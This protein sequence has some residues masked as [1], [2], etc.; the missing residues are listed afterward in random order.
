MATSMAMSAARSAMAAS[1][2]APV[3]SA[4]PVLR[5]APACTLALRTFG[6]LET[7]VNMRAFSVAKAAAA[8]SET[9]SSVIN[10]VEEELRYE[11]EAYKKPEVNALPMEQLPSQAT[12]Q[13]RR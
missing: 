6:G 3:P 4:V 9:V 10:A 11:K 12:V 7:N 5:M 1:S 2:R 8:Q 13:V